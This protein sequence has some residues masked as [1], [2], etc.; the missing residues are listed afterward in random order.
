[1]GENYGYLPWIIRIMEWFRLSWADSQ[2]VSSWSEF[3]P[4]P[5]FLSIET[6][7]RT[8]ECGR[9]DPD[10]ILLEGPGLT[11]NFKKVKI[12]LDKC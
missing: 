8:A 7:E 9:I 10:G 12:A 2:Y 1:M 4:D 5:G 6:Q 11:R 3:A